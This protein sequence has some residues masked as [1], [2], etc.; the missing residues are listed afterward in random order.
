MPNN[1]YC[2]GKRCSRC[3]HTHTPH[4]PCTF[5][6]TETSTRHAQMRPCKGSLRVSAGHTVSAHSL[7]RPSCAPPPFLG[8][9]Q[10]SLWH[11]SLRFLGHAWPWCILYTMMGV[12]K[13]TR[14]TDNAKAELLEERVAEGR[15]GDEWV[16][17]EREGDRKKENDWI[18]VIKAVIRSA[19]TCTRDD[20]AP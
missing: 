12:C 19:S 9:Q 7:F 8:Y 18:T 17:G 4:L 13:L 16:E 2:G 11:A 20:I 3:A 10:T 14:K 5:P 6:P 1:P 15:G